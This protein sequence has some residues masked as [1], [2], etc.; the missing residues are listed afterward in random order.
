MDNKNQIF[1]YLVSLDT[2][3][4]FD[5][6]WEDGLFFGRGMESIY[7][8]HISYADKYFGEFIGEL[9]KELFMITLS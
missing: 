5:E 7:K 9:K 6:N 3:F 8:N 1:A 4:P 2:H